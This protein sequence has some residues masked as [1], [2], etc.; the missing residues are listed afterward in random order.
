MAAAPLQT[1]IQVMGRPKPLGQIT[2]QLLEL[3][4]MPKKRP[5][6]KLLNANPRAHGAHGRKI[7]R[8]APVLLP[9]V[10]ILES[11]RLK[12][13]REHK[14][15][16]RVLADM[17]RLSGKNPKYHYFQNENELPLLMKLFELSKYRYLHFSC[18]GETDRVFTTYGE[19]SA[20][21]LARIFENKLVLKR[22]FF[23]A[24]KVGNSAFSE[25][26]AAKNKGM[27]S[28]VAPVPEI[29]FDHAAAMW[30]ALYV[31]LFAHNDER[32]THDGI[33]KRLRALRQLFPVDLHFSAYN[34]CDKENPWT[35]QTITR[36]PVRQH[37]T[38]Q[39]PPP[40]PTVAPEGFAGTHAP[41]P[42]LPPPTAPQAGAAG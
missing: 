26:I 34:S 20:Y 27:H 30:N 37:A 1:A 9:E 41:P 39:H 8:H 32:M 23:S 13:E 36:A 3:N 14:F 38:A 22:L 35:H 40:L 16:G 6:T 25:I 10:F 17:L 31:S 12:D 28:I 5:A 11:L 21:Q 42:A 29:R 19:I 18:H 33:L 15:E 2:P 24:C 4:H 7:R